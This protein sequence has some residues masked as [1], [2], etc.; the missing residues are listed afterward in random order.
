[1]DALDFGQ[2][3]GAFGGLVG[4]ERKRVVGLGQRPAALES[5]QAYAPQLAARGPRLGV[6]ADVLA[7]LRQ[8]PRPRVVVTEPAVCRHF[9][10]EVDTEGRPPY[11]NNTSASSYPANPSVVSDGSLSSS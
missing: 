4:V 10:H 5:E 9:E 8:P 6:G 1:V 7:L 3:V 2:D 11:L